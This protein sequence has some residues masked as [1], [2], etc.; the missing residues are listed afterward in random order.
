MNAQFAIGFIV[1]MCT[2]IWAMVCLAGWLIH[3]DNN[4]ELD[5]Q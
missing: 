5:E 4:S 3:S 2:T 1:G